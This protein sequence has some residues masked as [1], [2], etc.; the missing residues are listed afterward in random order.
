MWWARWG[1]GRRGVLGVAVQAEQQALVCVLGLDDRR[2]QDAR[3]CVQIAIGEL[4][5]TI[6]EVMGGEIEIEADDDRLR[7]RR[8]RGRAPVR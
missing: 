5:R 2:R 1:C 7:P 3:S 4:A 6:A 8:L